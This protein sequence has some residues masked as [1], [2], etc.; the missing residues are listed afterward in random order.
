MILNTSTTASVR[1]SECGRMEL[2]ELSIFEFSGF[3][4]VIKACSCGEEL[5]NIYS[6]DK[7]TYWF[8]FYCAICDNFHFMRLRRQDLWF[9]SNNVIEICCEETEI[10]VGYLGN[11]DFVQEKV[12]NHSYSL[13]EI[14]ER[15]GFTK[16]FYNSEVMYET[17]E[18]VYS[19]AGRD[20]L[21]C[22]CGNYDVEIEIFP[23][24]LE[25]LCEECG[26]R[27]KIMAETETD[28]E[29]LLSYSEIE[30][31]REGFLSMGDIEVGRFKE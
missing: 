16:Y 29:S 1:C 7:K 15:M 18:H 14:A 3:S 25:L 27:G 21:F 13:A 12:D 22:S 5:I 11:K 30:L 19:I 2:S 6:K 24:Y 23:E 10:E 31:T 8:Q 20:K 9:G 17:L 4:S 26:S 28:L